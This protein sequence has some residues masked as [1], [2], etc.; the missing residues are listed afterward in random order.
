MDDISS[1]LTFSVSYCYLF[2][3]FSQTV[4]G[5]FQHGLLLVSGVLIKKNCALLVQ[6]KNFSLR[7]AKTQKIWNDIIVNAL[8]QKF[9]SII[10]ASV[11][12]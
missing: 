7:S 6:K 2:Q 9:N 12:I 4:Y 8:F 5:P 3:I 11:F 10:T 1:G